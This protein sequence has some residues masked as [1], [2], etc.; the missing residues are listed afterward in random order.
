MEL[1]PAKIGYVTPA[2]LDDGNIV[3]FSCVTNGGSARW[4]DR[5][6]VMYK[7]KTECSRQG[8]RNGTDYLFMKT[9]DST[10]RIWFKDPSLVSY[11]AMW[12]EFNNKTEY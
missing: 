7:I 5:Q 2:K 9:T 8:L 11:M 1:N 6:K 3:E 12:D 4:H 10:I